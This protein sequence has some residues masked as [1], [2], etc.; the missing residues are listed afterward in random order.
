VREVRFEAPDGAR[1]AAL[2]TSVFA[3]VEAA[4]PGASQRSYQTEPTAFRPTATRTA[5]IWLTWL[6][7]SAA[8]FLPGA[9]VAPTLRRWDADGWV[10]VPA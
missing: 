9:P 1:L 5:P 3:A 8:L 10:P 6:G 7:L 4:V 2:E